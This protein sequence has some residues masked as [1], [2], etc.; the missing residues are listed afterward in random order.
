VGGKAPGRAR[1]V[2]LAIVLVCLAAACDWTAYLG[3]P[4]HHSQAADAGIRATDVP[5]LARRWRWHPQTIAD[6]PGSMFSTPATWR[7]T[8]FVGTN[9]GFL[10]ALDEGTGALRWQRDFGFQ[11]HLTCNAA[12]ISSSPAVRDD[13]AGTPLVYLNAPDG[14]LYELDGRTGSTVW[15]AEV[16]IPSTT[17][18]DAYAWASP[19]VANGR[20]YVGIASGC[21]NPFVRG[22]VKA[23]DQQT[24]ALLATA[25]LMP[26]GYVGAGVWTSVAAAGDAVYVTTGSTTSAV[27][28]AHPPTVANDFDQYS[29][30]K[31]DATTLAPL[32]KWPAPPTTVGDPDFGS[33]PIVFSATIGGQVLAMVGACNKDGNFYVVRSDTMQLV[34][35]RAVGT[36]QG[37][38]ERACLSGGVWDGA[39]LF[40]AA[41]TTTIGGQSVPGS[42]RQLDPATGAVVWERALPANPLGTGSANSAGLLAYAGTDWSDG[43]GNGVYVLDAASGTILRALDD[44]AEFPEFAQVVWADGRLFATNTD[45]VVMWSPPAH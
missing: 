22:A 39:R 37:A 3:G 12:G 5:L 32:G 10:A 43:P 13:G 33:S 25:W 20:V 31:L 41:N 16:Q 24:G 27:Q 19:T 2:A 45:A 6:R 30:V 26:S 38:G 29:I 28:S 9:S 42:V 11:P 15:R 40:V 35:S 4:D 17:V 34:W 21:D 7:G 14:Y 1:T 36:G 8:V 18:N 44:V 23:Y